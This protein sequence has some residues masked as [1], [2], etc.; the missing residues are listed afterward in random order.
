MAAAA[1]A[2][3]KLAP[4]VL[5]TG[6]PVC[7]VPFVASRHPRAA[8]IA[9]HHYGPRAGHRQ[10]H[11]Q[12]RSCSPVRLSPLS[13]QVAQ[14]RAA[15]ELSLLAF[16]NSTGMEHI[17]VGE[18]VSANGLHSGRD[19][20]FDCFILDE[21]KLCDALEDGMS[22]GG[23]VLD[24]HS[25]DF[26]PERWFDVVVCLQTDNTV[27]YDRLAARGYSQKKI[28]ENVDCEIM[29]EVVQ[30]VR[31][32]YQD[33]VTLV[34]QSDTEEQQQRNI[35][36]I[37]QRIQQWSAGAS[38]GSGAAAVGSSGGGGGLAKAAGGGGYSSSSGSRAGRF[39]PF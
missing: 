27:L 32:F 15:A 24:H 9:E 37:L 23:K 33:E 26:Y 31:E 20:E 4:N 16:C 12:R 39:Q 11:T 2:T 29:Q 30:D 35:E 7:T 10:N 34:L 19:E 6:T 5:I 28:T 17:N 38:N 1:A 18:F 22:A 3:A 8:C 36:T 25:C 21:D 13:P 14:H